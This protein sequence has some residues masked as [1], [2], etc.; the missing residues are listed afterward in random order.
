MTQESS[1]TADLGGSSREGLSLL[2]EAPDCEVW[3]T[4]HT[5]NFCYE[6]GGGVDSRLSIT[7]VRKVLEVYSKRKYIHVLGSPGFQS[8]RYDG[9]GG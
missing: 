9:G 3:R 2:R 6:G 8:D 4:A 7:S 5:F 1:H